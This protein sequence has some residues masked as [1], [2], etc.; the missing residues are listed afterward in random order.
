MISVHFLLMSQH[1]FVTI[2]SMLFSLLFFGKYYLFSNVF[3]PMCAVNFQTS[4]IS[5][6]RQAA[7]RITG[8][9]TDTYQNTK[10]LIA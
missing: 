4:V 3:G 2:T 5:G 10:E 9:P 6:G 1:V 8:A 7:S